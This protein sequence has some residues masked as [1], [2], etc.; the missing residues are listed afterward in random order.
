MTQKELAAMIDMT[1][2]QNHH[3]WTEVEGLAE[4]A[5][6]YHTAAVFVMPCYTKM[7]SERLAGSG[8][9]VGGT[10]G[11]PDGAATTEIKLLEAKDSLANG[12]EEL[13]MVINLGWLKSGMDEQVRDEI[14][15]LKDIVGERPLKCIIEINDLTEDE[16][17]R[18]SMLVVEGGAD[19]V[20][21]STGW[22]GG[23]KLEHIQLIRQTIGSAAKIKAAGGIRT[24]ETAES[25][26]AAGASRLGIGSESAVKILESM[27]ETR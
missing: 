27:P 13:D 2:V 15:R 21:T 16:A 25:F 24:L 5:V 26:I 9:C 8:V 18:A 7:L 11:F 22:R 12:A 10:A 6:K 4:T 23:T 1:M 19:Y 3:T 20:K 14:R 17:K